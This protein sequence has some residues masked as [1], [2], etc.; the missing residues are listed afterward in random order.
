MSE[1]HSKRVRLDR[2]ELLCWVGRRCDH[3]GG[4]GGGGGGGGRSSASKGV[5]PIK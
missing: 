4:G 5:L 3:L 1:T 2:S